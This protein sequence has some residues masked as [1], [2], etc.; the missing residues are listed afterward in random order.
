MLPDYAARCSEQWSLIVLTMFIENNRYISSPAYEG[1]EDV[2]RF[3]NEI[4]NWLRR[5]ENEISKTLFVF[6]L[7]AVS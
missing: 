4:L 3:R 6:Y 2:P 5:A 7:C 1:A